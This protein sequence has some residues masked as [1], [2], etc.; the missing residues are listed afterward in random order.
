MELV[1]H[2]QA[3]SQIA[4]HCFR[5]RIIG[6]QFENSFQIEPGVSSEKVGRLIMDQTG[7]A[8]LLENAK[9]LPND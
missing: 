2:Y 3:S 6:S 1:N 4:F 7:I 8:S 5:T 9:R